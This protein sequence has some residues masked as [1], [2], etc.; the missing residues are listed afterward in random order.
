MLANARFYQLTLPLPRS[1]RS[2][3]WSCFQHQKDS[4][5]R[6]APHFV[7]G[8]AFKGGTTSLYGYLAQHPQ[9]A[10]LGVPSPYT[11]ATN[12]SLPDAA[13]V[14]IKE[15]VYWGMRQNIGVTYNAYRQ[16]MPFV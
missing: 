3:A 9:V 6:C 10:L 5:G 16:T 15:P 4:S 1:Y 13:M 11:E 14:H 12:V 8:G 7:V 2:L